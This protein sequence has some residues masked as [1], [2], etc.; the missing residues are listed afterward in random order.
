MRPGA[1]LAQ[2]RTHLARALAT[3][4]RLGTLGEPDKVRQMLDD[5]PA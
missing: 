5:L 2:R 4:E 1:L 3:F